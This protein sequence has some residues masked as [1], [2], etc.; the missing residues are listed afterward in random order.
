MEKEKLEMKDFKIVIDLKDLYTE[1][2]GYGYNDGDFNQILKD[3]IQH[4]VINAIIKGFTPGVIKALK[5]ETMSKFREEF[6][7]KIKERILKTIHRGV[8]VDTYGSA[9]SVDSLI[10]EKFQDA[11]R[12]F[13]TSAIDKSVKRQIDEMHEALKE[14][15]DLAFASGIIKTLRD[16]KLLKD[17]A[18]KLLIKE[19]EI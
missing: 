19:E 14:R 11:D 9:Y 15:Y 12:D 18:E 2:D 1:C 4:E 8:F 7:A 16:N 5:E 10:R 6:D 13:F 3:N 17:G